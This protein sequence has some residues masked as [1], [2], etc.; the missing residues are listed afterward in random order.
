MKNKFLLLMT[1]FFSF[2]VA[3]FSASSTY[4]ATFP[5]TGSAATM[6]AS[7]TYEHFSSD[8]S[9]TVNTATGVFSGYFWEANVGWVAFG[10][11][12]NPAGPVQMNM[13]TGVVTGKAKVLNTGAYLDFTNYN[14]NVTIN[15]STG[16]F[17]GYAFEEDNG[18]VAFGTTDN[19]AGPV[20]MNTTTGIVGGTALVLNTGTTL[21]TTNYTSNVT[22]NIATKT[23]SGYA[24][25]DNIGWVAFGT[26]DNPAG[27]V[28]FDVSTGKLSGKARALNTGAY[29]DFGNYNSNVKVNLGSGVFS[30]YAF[31]EDMGWI[32]FSDT[33]V[34][35]GPNFTTDASAPVAYWKMDE[36]YG[37]TVN[38]SAKFGNNGTLSG[39]TLPTWQT[40]DQCLS[41][42]CLYFNGGTSNVSVSN[43][44]NNVQTL[45][46]WAKPAT[47]TASFIQLATGV[48]VKATNGT[49]QTDGFTSPTIYVNGTVNRQLTANSWNHIEITTNSPVAAGAIT[50]GSMQTGVLNGFLDD[51]KLFNYARTQSQ[52]LADFNGRGNA[53]GAAAVMGV[54]INNQFSALN[55][56]LVGYWKMDEATWS[57]TLGEVKDSSGNGN[58]GQ[59][60]GP[61]NSKAYPGSPSKFGSAGQFDGIDNY[62]SIPDSSS[63]DISSAFSIAFWIKYTSS[64]NQVI[65][66]K[67]GNSGYS[68]Q[69]FGGKPIINVGGYGSAQS[70][71]AASSWNDGNWHH[72]VFVVSKFAVGAGKV[73]VDGVDNTGS[74]DSAGTPSY[75][76]GTSLYIGGRTGT[77]VYSGSLDEVRIY[78]RAL[79][80]ADVQNL[81][82]YAPGPVAYYNFEEGSGSSVN[83]K[84]GNGNNGSWEGTLGEQWKQG[85]YGWGGNFDGS[86]NYVYIGNISS[87]T[88]DRTNAFTISTWYKTNTNV[89]YAML[90][91]KLLPLGNYTGYDLQIDSG[92][93]FVFELVSV[94]GTNQ[95]YIETANGG[96]NDGR[97]HYVTVTTDG[98]GKVAGTKIYVDGIS[99]AFNPSVEDNL[100][101][102][103]VSNE[104]LSLGSRNSTFYFPGQLDETRIYNYARSP[105]QII[106][107]MNGGAST[108]S[109]DPG[110]VGYWKFDEGYGTTANNSGNGGSALNGTL[111]GTT[112]P[113]WTN[114]G[115]YAK[116]LNFGGSNAYITVGNPAAAQITSDLTISAWVN[117]TTN[118]AVHDLVA[119]RGASG[120]YGY[121]LFT[122]ASGHPTLEVSSDGTVLTTTSSSTILSTGAWY[123]LVGVYS[124]GNS[125][126]LY[127]NSV[128]NNQNTIS[129]P[130]S[131]KNSS[132]NLEIGSENGG[133]INV[134][135]GILDDV[136]IYPYALTSSEVQMDYNRNSGMVF[137]SLS[138]D[139][140]SQ[141][142]ASNSAS[143][144]YCVPG[145]T[146]SCAAPVGEWN[147]EEGQ[148]GT[149]HDTSGN[150]NDGTWNG[151]GP[152]HYT[153]GHSSGPGLNGWAGNFNGTSDYVSVTNTISGIKTVGFWVY[154]TST[155]GG[156]I[157][158]DS[159]THYISI[160]SG[161]LSATGFVSPTVYV[162]G[163]VASTISANSWQFIEVTTTTGINSTNPLTIG[164]G[165]GT[166]FTGKIDQ[167]RIFNYARTPAQVA[168]DYN[169]G[170]PVGWWKFDE[171]QGTTVNDSS[172]NGNFGTIT[173]GG[174]GTDVLGTCTG[175]T[176]SAWKTGASGK[177][178]SSLYFDGAHD[179]VV[180]TASLTPA[181]SGTLSTWVYPDSSMLSVSTF[182]VIVRYAS[183]P[184]IY[185]DTS[186]HPFF[187]G[188]INSSTQTCI[189]SQT[190]TANSWQHLVSTYNLNG[191]N[192]DLK[193][194]INGKLVCSS[195]KTGT[196]NQTSALVQIGG[197][198]SS[199]YYKGQTD[200]TR[201][202]NYA[203]T[204]M[205]IQLLYN[206]G[207]AVRFAPVTGAP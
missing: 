71:W 106:Q 207:A 45:S 174:S 165:N 2:F 170:A 102:S 158:L 98:S 169:R 52:V 63:L 33:G 43:T 171:C 116:A 87:L 137:G 117:L 35:A 57:G 72:V 105:K 80:P 151:T 204:P 61:T 97:W 200:D 115:K 143:A 40:E 58:N 156:I 180:T 136:K 82:N 22:M 55:Q 11:T 152:K 176:A 194:Y 153:S 154:P 65:F 109:V 135:N 50:L 36:G 149:V 197:A 30:G 133:G 123:Q 150:G 94:L 129:I 173:V 12:D 128:Q 60:Q 205:Q 185:I 18:W 24:W 4:A 101:G 86:S 147:F 1:L 195:T 127:V 166:Y 113:A 140:S 15:T 125:L 85:K 157:D 145:D 32:N 99:Q 139:Q 160:S 107:D 198:I 19:P 13:T 121:R 77:F 146:T 46:F 31:S 164:K 190:L 6:N 131:I 141:H 126:T 29:I 201:I 187:Q 134:L 53:K 203:L 16:V 70:T 89:S 103:T 83:D 95:I 96:F 118:N 100:T 189:P 47:S 44:I 119:K 54:G 202:Y 181:T 9:L 74:N 162:N 191:G 27:P 192:T 104:P 184:G 42:K 17:S 124:A 155:T 108:V 59:A 186:G 41:G 7:G 188:T 177:F 193:F 5:V 120:Q 23:F 161:T 175:S 122:D 81:Y 25:E 172:G 67:N 48:D 142:L 132:A 66:E 93:Y 76:S 138:T 14:S 91:D 3:S 51:T 26:T 112:K 37:T 79:S 110:A 111:S 34:S 182:P 39:T 114:S 38:D 148:G 206:G 90:V 75:G 168:W 28:T 167:I 159:G 68:V 130:S 144:Q 179:N 21:G 84:S 196:L 178:N 73:Y 56:G 8:K 199:Q 49:V 62:V 20:Q 64:V 183:E 69:L 92:G 163:Q 88:F 10:T 78:N